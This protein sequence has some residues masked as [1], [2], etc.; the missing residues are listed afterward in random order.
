MAIIVDKVQ[1]RKDIALS[2]RE[3]FVENGIS[4]LTISRI[5]K[6][7]GVGKGTLYE[8]FENK[9]AIVFELVD[10]LMKEHSE[11]LHT[12]L[13]EQGSVRDMVKKFAEFFYVDENVELRTLY[14]EFISLSLVTPNKEMLAY[15]TECF[16]NYYSWFEEI[17]KRGVEEGELIAQAVGLIKGL[18]VTA[19]GM[20]IA[21]TSTN[22]IENLQEDLNSYIDN[23]FELIEVK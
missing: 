11:K 21:S 1:K 19:E 12:T 2:C 9:E 7:A 6:T 3:L 23:I 16:N 10:I 17:F 5:A 4:D 20:F 18:F 22:A 13:L 15:Q 8:Y 14:K